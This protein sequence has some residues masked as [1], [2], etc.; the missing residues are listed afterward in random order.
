[1]QRFKSY[2]IE[3]KSKE[4]IIT[5]TALIFMTLY[6]YHGVPKFFYSFIAPMFGEL[7]L[8]PFT[9]FVSRTYQCLFVFTFFF[10]LPALIVKLKYREKIADYGFQIGDTSFG[11]RFLLIAIPVVLP[12][13]Y[14][15][16]FQSDFQLEYPLPLLARESTKYLLVWECFYLFYYIGWE[17]LFR[18]Y[19]LFGLEKKIGAYWAVIFQTLP[20]TIIHIGKPE[21]E[22]ISAIIAGIVFGV[23]ALRTRSI[24]YPL[25]LH[26]IV[27]ISMD[28][29]SV[30]NSR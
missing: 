18:G 13:I 12:F 6:V 14:I 29:F 26:Y 11:I 8:D 19:I 2:F 3:L 22:T 20:S 21:G 28:V 1:M 25:I 7:M 10:V 23:V 16:S 30:I 17:F 5:I 4:S 27:G 15:S 24:I 9:D